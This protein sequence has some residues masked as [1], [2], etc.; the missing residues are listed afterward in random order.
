MAKNNFLSLTVRVC[1]AE[2]ISLVS[3]VPK[4][5]IEGIVLGDPNVMSDA[6]RYIIISEATFAP[7]FTV[8]PVGDPCAI[9]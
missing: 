1:G 9:D 8:T 6:T 5:Y 4:F 2:T 3:S 7:W